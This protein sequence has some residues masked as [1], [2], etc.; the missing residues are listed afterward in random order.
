MDLE[1]FRMLIHELLNKDPDIVLEEA[2]LIILDS[3][4]AVCTVKNGKDTN[5]IRHISKKLYFVRNGEKCKMHK[6]DWCE[7]GLQLAD[8]AAK[9]VGEN[10]LNPRMKYIMVRLDN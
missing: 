5:N 6:V 2:P 1:N 4:S 8:I 10:Y 7:G 3:K 9:N